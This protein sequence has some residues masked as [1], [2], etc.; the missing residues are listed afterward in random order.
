MT[1]YAVISLPEEEGGDIVS[2]RDYKTGVI[3]FEGKYSSSQISKTLGSDSD[4]IVFF[5]KSDRF[6]HTIVEDEDLS[7]IINGTTSIDNTQMTIINNY[8][9][10]N[11]ND[12]SATNERINKTYRNK[13]I[14]ETDWT[15]A[16]DITDDDLIKSKKGKTKDKTNHGKSAWAKY[17]KDLRDLSDHPNWPNLQPEDWPTPPDEDQIPIPHKP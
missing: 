8:F 4:A 16:A 10:R 9:Y 17:R 12:K 1:H 13:L 14:S 11:K 7:D 3:V 5:N 6:I 2:I 15:Q